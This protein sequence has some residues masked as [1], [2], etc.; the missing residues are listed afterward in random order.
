MIY[1][2]NQVPIFYQITGQGPAVILLHG[3]LERSTMWFRLI[4][5]LIKKN[6]VITLDLPGHGKS[7]SIAGTHSMELMAE[8]VFSLLKYLKIE[9]ASFI[10]HSMGGYV[11][12]AF[13]EAYEPMMD[14][15]ILLNSTSKADSPERKRNRERALVVISENKKLFIGSAINNLFTENARLKYPL[16]IA[17]LKDQAYSFPVEGIKAAILGMKDRKDRT[18]VL[19][20]FRREKYLICGD[21]DPIVPIA[22]SKAIAAATQCELKVLHGGH[23]SWIENTAEMLKF[24]I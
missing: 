8:V 5:E 10:G 18:W 22:D 7:G 20:K 4:P 13:A 12:L 11:T 1:H 19:E 17:T 3:F 2:Y 14:R 16:E 21:E 23:M 24:Y 9:S 15:L 6:T